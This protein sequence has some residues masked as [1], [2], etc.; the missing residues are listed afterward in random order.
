VHVIKDALRVAVL[1]VV[2]LICS[3]RWLA[4]GVSGCSTILH[5]PPQT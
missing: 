5:S 2:V 4:M 3:T 1:T